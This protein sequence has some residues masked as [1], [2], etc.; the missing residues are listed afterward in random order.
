MR[1][2]MLGSF[3]RRVFAVSE[4]RSFAR[5]GS[6]MDIRRGVA[7][8]PRLR[9]GHSVEHGAAPPRFRRG[10]SVATGARLRY[11]EARTRDV[12]GPTVKVETERKTSGLFGGSAKKETETT[13]TTTVTEHLWKRTWRVRIRAFRGD[14]EV[15]TLVD[16]E[17][18]TVEATRTKDAPRTDATPVTRRLA[19]ADWLASLPRSGVQFSIDRADDKTRTPR[20]NA[21]VDEVLQRLLDLSRFANAVS[22]GGIGMPPDFSARGQS[23]TPRGSSFDE[24]RRRRRGESVKTSRGDA[25]G[26]AWIVRGGERAGARE[27]RSTD[28]VGSGRLRRGCDVELSVETG[29]SRRV[30]DG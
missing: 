10:N 30:H 4:A 14:V 8:P 22:R 13:V 1:S 23:T 18:K 6:R 20:R 17:L 9:R 15:A 16:H 24:S 12:K 19:D 11:V 21:D 28:S 7:A 27:E 26:A 3:F 29:L 2:P 25:A 5:A